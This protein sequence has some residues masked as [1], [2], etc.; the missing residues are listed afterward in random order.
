MSTR[1]A[2]KAGSWYTGDA[3]A[4]DQQLDEFLDLVPDTINNVSLPVAGARVIIAP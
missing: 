1:P 2:T 3:D 4:L